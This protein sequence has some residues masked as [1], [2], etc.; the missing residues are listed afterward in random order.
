MGEPVG[1]QSIAR[2]ESTADRTNPSYGLV[3]MKRPKLLRLMQPLQ[4]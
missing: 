4:V 2:K 3:E 1:R